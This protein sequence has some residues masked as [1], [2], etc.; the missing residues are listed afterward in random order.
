MSRRVL[1]RETTMH[2]PV[3]LEYELL[4]SIPESMTMRKGSVL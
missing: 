3:A 1:Q 2:D 4:E